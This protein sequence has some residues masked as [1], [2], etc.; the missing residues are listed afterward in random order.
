MVRPVL[1]DGIPTGADIEVPVLVVEVVDE[2][3]ADSESEADLTQMVM[4]AAKR[5]QSVQESASIVTVVTRGQI[6]VRG[7]RGFADVLDQ[8]PGFEGY[9]PSFY[10]NGDDAFARGNAR[11]M[12]VLW[13]GVPLNSPQ[14]NQRALG[15]YLPL[16]VVDRVEVLSGPGGVMWG[17][18]AVLGVTSITTLRQGSANGDAEVTG[19]IGGGP[20]AA[21]EYRASA[22]VA[23]SFLDDGVRVY[24][25]LGLITTL[26]PV[27][28]PP[29]DL[30]VGPFPAPDTDG[31]FQ[32]AH[33]TGN[34]QAARDV[35]MPLTLAVDAGDFR[36]DLF[37]PFMAREY[38]EFNDFGGRTDQVLVG[39]EMIIPGLSS[40]RSEVVTAM[41]VRYEK[42]LSEKQQLSAKVY[43]TTF[44]DRW[45]RLVKYAPGLLS[46]TA[47]THD[48]HYTGMTSWLHDGAYRYGV[49]VDD[50]WSM[51][52][53]QLVFGGETYLEGIREIRA[54][55]TGVANSMEHPAYMP[56]RRL[57]TAVFA[58]DNINLTPHVSVDVGARAQYAPGSY[59]PLVLGSFAARWNPWEKLNLKVNVA[60]GFR[61]PAFELTNGNDDPVTNPWAHRQ[62]N[63][64]LDPERSLSVEGEVS[65][66]MLQ[67][68]GPL[69]FAA[70]RVGYQYTRL[71]DLIVFDAGGRPANANRRVMNSIEARADLSMKGGHRFVLGYS[72]LVGE[73]FETGPLRNLPEHRLNLTFEQHVHD[74]V[75][76]YLG[77]AVTGVVE[78]LDR[79]PQLESTGYSTA[80]PSSVV[81][82]RLP[83]TGV[84]SCGVVA[85]GL[86][87]GK[88]D[89][90]A[91]VQNAF[92]TTR[93]I[94]D[95]DFERRQAILP[96]TAPGLSAT[97]SATWRM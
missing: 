45:V 30:Q 47:F 23:H 17:A 50:S 67:D 33:S 42:R 1:A 49:S 58:D 41:S 79:M 80:I 89:L 86:L 54:I 4:S 94:A 13:N 69:K 29:Y 68:R 26:G 84:V 3:H 18:N 77:L 44:E 25:N 76:A 28:D 5:V 19:S 70:W 34:T 39:N 97:V 60:Q 27:I 92:D 53:Q 74:H 20:G 36:F 72:F 66:M 35:W 61:P 87:D 21:G 10:L 73:D 55:A 37:Y 9:R 56:G 52:R 46:P 96:M 59:A 90:S 6:Q 81:V 88:L 31:A 71:D 93:Y 12:L 24:A 62:S 40:E 16:E 14:T 11:T 64:D 32:L 85:S 22:T 65:A 15:P 2:E 75:D 95:P 78:D 38:R 7:Y 63:P 91:Q 82:D 48:E 43:A 83:P 8:I 51:G 57:V